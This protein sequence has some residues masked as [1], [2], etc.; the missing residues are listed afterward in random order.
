M[1]LHIHD[2]N[3]EDQILTELDRNYGLTKQDYLLKYLEMHNK[4]CHLLQSRKTEFNIKYYDSDYARQ[5]MKQIS[6]ID[7][8][9]ANS[10]G[11]TFFNC[12]ENLLK[13]RSEQQFENYSKFMTSKFVAYDFKHANYFIKINV[14]C[15]D[16]LSMSDFIYLVTKERRQL[17]GC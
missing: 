13:K 15:I 17:K 2:R 6:K 7:L 12:D 5:C 3:S 16:V 8:S 1:K 9:D 4:W 10:F 14:E 11:N